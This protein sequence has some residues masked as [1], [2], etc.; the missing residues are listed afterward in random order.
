[1]PHLCAAYIFALFYIFLALYGIPVC[2]FKF[3]VA[4]SHNLCYHKYIN[5]TDAW[6]ARSA[7]YF[8]QNPAA[9]FIA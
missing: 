4:I 1:M 9:D 2:L 7:L 5:F 6:T 3:Y 8:A